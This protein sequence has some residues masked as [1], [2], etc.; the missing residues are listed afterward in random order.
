MVKFGKLY[1]SIQIP[2][3]T[4]NYIDYKK[5][6]QKIKKIKENIPSVSTSYIS[7]NFS[8]NNLKYNLNLSISNDEYIPNPLKLSINDGEYNNHL[9]E[10]KNL[11]DNEFQKFFNFFLKVKRR[12]HKK[13]N[14]HL[15]TQTNYSTYKEAEL[16]EEINNLRF[17]IYLAKCLNAFIHDNMM[18][19]KK[20]LKKFDKKFNNY[21]GN[22]GPRYI[23][24]NLCKENSDLEYLLQ[25]KII[26]EACCI[27][28]DNTKLLK[29][30]YLE[31]VSQNGQ[32]INRKE[33]N[34]FIKYNEIWE[35]LIDIDELIYFKIQYKEWFYYIKKDAVLKKQS[36]LFKNLLFNPILYSRG[37][38]YPRGTF[39]I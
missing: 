11:L 39:I 17:T 23:L 1:R 14:K 20:I 31:V 21:F 28:E 5:L 34:F 25:F 6:K 3:F 12:L 18:A 32:K 27:I 19:I 22:F 38:K 9:V 36:A 26:D 10:F 15:Y 2:E 24:D 16:V 33:D 7:N 4:G 29:D 37:R 35:Y 30:C 8:F 13:L